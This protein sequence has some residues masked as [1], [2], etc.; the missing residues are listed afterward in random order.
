MLRIHYFIVVEQLVTQRAAEQQP[1][2]HLLLVLQHIRE[3]KVW[4]TVPYVRDLN[5]VRSVD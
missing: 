2:A 5:L 1:H 3:W 4:T